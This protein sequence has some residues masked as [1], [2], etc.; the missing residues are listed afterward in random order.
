M[1]SQ[2][3]KCDWSGSIN[4][5]TLPRLAAV[6]QMVRGNDKLPDAINRLNAPGHFRCNACK[7]SPRL[8]RPPSHHLALDKAGARISAVSPQIFGSDNR[9]L[10]TQRVAM[11]ARISE[12]AFDPAGKVNVNESDNL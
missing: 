8:I 1:G 7:L 11:P 9:H 12:F 5:S 4:S 2:T 10:F 3:I 6:D